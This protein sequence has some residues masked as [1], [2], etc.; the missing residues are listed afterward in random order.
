MTTGGPQTMYEPGGLNPQMTHLLEPIE[1]GVFK[2]TGF[3]V[4]PAF[5][6]WGPARLSPEEG[7]QTLNDYAEH[8]RKTRDLAGEAPLNP[9]EYPAPTFQR[10]Q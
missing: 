1:H 4:L 2:F 8:L 3:H 10:R 7:E 5:F 9:D 6:V